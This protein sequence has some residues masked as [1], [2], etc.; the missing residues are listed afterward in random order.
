MH[1]ASWQDFWAMGGAGR[2]VWGAYGLVGLAFAA[3][4]WSLRARVR[5]ARETV[6]RASNWSSKEPQS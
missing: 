5:R 1:W 4:I 3:E 6:R 2:Y